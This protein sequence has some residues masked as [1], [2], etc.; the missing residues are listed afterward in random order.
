MRIGVDCDGV[1]TDLTAYIRDRGEKY[2]DRKMVNTGAY[3][4]AGIF[5]CSKKEELR[6]WLKYFVPYC[7]EWPP[8]NAAAEVLNG[9]HND[10]HELYE[11]TARM[12]VTEKNPLGWY[13]R[14]IFRNWIRQH[15][16]HFDGIHFCAEERASE[17]KFA[18]CR[19]YAVDLMID[20]KPDVA[21]YLAENG[22]RVLLFDTLYNQDVEHKHITRVYSWENIK[23]II[24]SAE[25]LSGQT[26]SDTSAV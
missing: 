6:F 2:F 11:I 13:S 22:I 18:G 19:K 1:L 16:F 23:Q 20:D 17:D 21:L 9:L 7:K 10:G 15:G 12:F 14:R 26:S 8:R 25:S 4:V 5:Q 24:Q 3:N